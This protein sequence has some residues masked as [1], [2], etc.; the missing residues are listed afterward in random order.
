MPDFDLDTA[1]SSPHLPTVE[2][3]EFVIEIDAEYQD[4]RDHF[5]V[6]ADN[7]DDAAADEAMLDEIEQR[8]RRGDLWAFCSVCVKA[9]WIDPETDLE[10][11]GT[12]YLGGCS[13]ADEEDF[14][15][16]GGYYQQMQKEAFNDLIKQIESG[17]GHAH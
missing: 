8:L 4:P 3:V 11:E 2:E 16:P 5:P 14:K 12:D 15:Q 17:N 7:A 1:L 9:I 6:A 10:F 13:Y